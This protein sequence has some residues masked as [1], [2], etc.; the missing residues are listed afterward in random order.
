M[1]LCS[2]CAVAF[3]A[4]GR[5]ALLSGSRV[6]TA[7]SLFSSPAQI[8]IGRPSYRHSWRAFS[9]SALAASAKVDD[10]SSFDFDEDGRSEQMI[11]D[12]PV[13]PP[14]PESSLSSALTR[15]STV[16]APPPPSAR[17]SAARDE[18]SLRLSASPIFDRTWRSRDRASSS[19]AAG[20]RTSSATFSTPSTAGNASGSFPKSTA[21]KRWPQRR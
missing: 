3:T 11:A 7:P 2:R 20:P 5:V 6:C 14:P 1:T 21:S 15:A 16:M 19:P 12:H 13:P 18:P 4:G 10:E 8:V 17:S 9:P